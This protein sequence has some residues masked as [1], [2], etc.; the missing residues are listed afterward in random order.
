[1]AMLLVCW[2]TLMR[3]QD[4]EQGGDPATSPQSSPADLI[5]TDYLQLQ[6]PI[7]LESE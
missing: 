5:S 2:H 1:M 6:P 3:L 4:F 7:K